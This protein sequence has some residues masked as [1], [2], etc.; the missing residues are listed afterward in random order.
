MR[1]RIA[2]VCPLAKY[3]RNLPKLYK[4]AFSWNFT[5]RLLSKYF[6]I[7]AKN[8]ICL[9]TPHFLRNCQVLSSSHEHSHLYLYQQH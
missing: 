4:K 9:F 7:H 3:L 5:F 6:I 2:Q 1:K 8:T